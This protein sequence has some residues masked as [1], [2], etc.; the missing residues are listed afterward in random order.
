MANT[1][2]NYTLPLIPVRGLVVFPYMVLHFDVAREK[3]IAALEEAM[4]ADQLVFLAA[5][6]DVS[7]EEP[8]A[9]DIYEI[10]C[11][12]K[13]KQMLKMPGGN[14]RVLVEGLKRAAFTKLDFSLPYIKAGVKVMFSEGGDID[15]NSLDASARRMH[16]LLAKISQLSGQINIDVLN[17]I[18]LTD[19]P[20]LM[21]D[22]IASNVFVKVADKQEILSE[23]NIE[24]RIK[25][26]IA[27]LFREVQIYEL[28][29]QIALETKKQIDK[30]QKDYLLREQM[31]VIQTELGDTSADEAAEY[32]DLV[33]NS[34]LPAEAAAKVT[35]EI[36][37]LSS[38][39]FGSAEITVVKQWLDV[40][41]DLPWNK[42]T[43]T[44]ADLS[45][46][47]AVLEADHYGLYKVKER[48]LEYLAV[49]QLSGS[50]KGPI[51]CLVGPPGVGKTSIAQ[52]IAK[53]TGRE[54]V[55][56]SL[57]GVKDEAEI[58]GHRKTY[59]GAMPGRII[60]ALR[61]AKSKNALILLDEIDKLGNDF[62]GDPASAMLEVLDSAQNFAFRDHY[63][64]LPFDLS[65]ILFVT[66]A[67]NLDTIPSALKDRLE[68]IELT[69]YTT[70]E[71]LHIALNYLL[72]RQLTENGL[73]RN[74]L[75]IDESVI[76]AVIENYTAEAGVRNLERELGTI[77]RKVAK[78]IV[79]ENRKTVSVTKSNLKK[80]LG[81]KKYTH[82]KIEKESEPGVV[83]GLAWT[84]VGGVT[85]TVEVNIMEGTGKVE[86]T[87]SL[88]EVMKE[89][90]K[91]AI[92]YIRANVSYYGIS[93]DFYKVKDIHV[94]VPEG[95]TPKD[96]PSAGITIA[97]AIISAL[98]NC[99]VKSSVAMTGE[100][101]LRGRVL[102]IGGLKEKL[103]AAYR[104]G[105]TTVIIPEDNRANLEDIPTDVLSAVKV[106]PVRNMRS[107]IDIAI[108]KKKSASEINEVLTDNEHSG[109]VRIT[110]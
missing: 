66:T 82:D 72:P 89:S 70:E 76:E 2:K 69:G 98:T 9:S 104:A 47:S 37:R 17:N 8:G 87:G 19:E 95:A 102:P 13:I 33:Q 100:I 67:N 52:S 4:A 3:S 58:R 83:T 68:I 7:V 71:K 79:S 32:R 59:V 35:K 40:V 14:V 106:I 39:P 49:R 81:V 44:N 84:S 36:H 62:R 80:F 25:K 64:E 56:M 77:C 15:P 110:N 51:L 23:L 78:A 41:F 5:Q 26:T 86:L 29:Q 30:N 60:N 18:T 74:N 96:G 34:D 53:A 43:E 90:A 48:I 61:Q 94:H 85:L 92:S 91:A 42:S 65:Q 11:I 108:G 75:K 1:R 22:S 21:A 10:G 54:Y 50:T 107:V 105:V 103:L 57:G 93:Q 16:E 31:K 99:S 97:T 101:T 6:K 27:I 88:G 73:K 28:E 45:K 12:S 38:M 46:A 20:G 63:L 55:R 24:S 109:S